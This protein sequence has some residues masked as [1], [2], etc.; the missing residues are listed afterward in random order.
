M[1]II[2]IEFSIVVVGQDCNPTILNPDFLKVREIVPEEWG[3]QLQGPPITTPPF[4]RVSYDSRVAINVEPNRVQITDQATAGDVA[5]S[6]VQDI[7]R[8]YIRT[9][10]HVRYT[11]VG[12]NFRA[13]VEME[14]PDR[15]LM[16]NFLSAAP[17][18]G[19]LGP[20]TAATLKFVYP[21]EQGLLHLTLE[22]AAVVHQQEDKSEEKS[23]VLVGAN[24]HREC[25]G[26]PTDTQ[27]L[28]HL[29]H[30]TAD[31]E[32]FAYVL[33]HLPA[34]SEDN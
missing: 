12:I 19:D 3:W 22:G 2:P 29:E 10:P 4:A 14:A 16:D 1:N 27:V 34:A 13:L 17:E 23:G 28:D 15:Y 31:A 26:Y 9:L 30:A 33:S 20:P 11:G 6:K 32:H 25:H 7:V 8:T 18:S 24:Y 5:A 21:F